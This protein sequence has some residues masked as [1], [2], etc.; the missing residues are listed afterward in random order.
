MRLRPFIVLLP[1]LV[2]AGAARADQPLLL[3]PGSRV[4]IDGDSTVTRYSLDAEHPAVTV[5][6]PAAQMTAGE[7]HLLDLTGLRAELAVQSLHSETPLLEGR[8]RRALDVANHP[9][10]TLVVSGVRVVSAS[11]QSARLQAAV[12]LT[13]KG[14]KKTLPFELEATPGPS[15]LRVA[16]DLPVHLSDFSVDPP[17][18]LGF[19][20][21]SNDVRV[22]VDL[23]LPTPAIAAR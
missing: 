12:E 20:H 3:G 4:R 6:D 17:V 23:R 15:G 11:A 8:V 5:P 22:H 1:L 10:L 13:L 16:G 9:T 18:V 14:V 2:A 21:A 7:L 19:I